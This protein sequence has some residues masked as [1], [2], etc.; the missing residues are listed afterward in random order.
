MHGCLW[1]W[2]VIGLAWVFDDLWNK[3][4]CV[5]QCGVYELSN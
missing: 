5:S 1:V 4:E 3:A 2:L